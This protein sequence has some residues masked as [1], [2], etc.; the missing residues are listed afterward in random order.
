MKKKNI[1][2]SKI[3]RLFVL[4]E[5]DPVVRN[6]GRTRVRW[7]CACDCGSITVALASSIGKG[8]N[9]CGCLAVE[10]IAEQGR[11]NKI[12]GLTDTRA[13]LSWQAMINRCTKPKNNRFKHYG[14]RGIK[15]CE[16]WMKFTNFFADMGQRPVG[17]TLERKD[18]NGNYEP[19]NCKWATQ[20]EQQRNRRNSKKNR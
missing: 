20:L 10:R 14:G 9:S 16:R 17:L 5:F 3:G 19:G 7:V 8:T 15:V 4:D 18:V 11:K 6:D 1:A 2:G 13:H 12:H